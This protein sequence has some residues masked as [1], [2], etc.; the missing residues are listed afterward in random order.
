MDNHDDLFGNEALLPAQF[1]A[2]RGERLN[3]PIKRLALAVLEDALRLYQRGEPKRG[4]QARSAYVE[5]VAWLFYP[6]EGPFCFDSVCEILG[7]EAEYLRA[8]LQRWDREE[9]IAKR[10][11]VNG[12]GGARP[13][14]TR[15]RGHRERG[16]V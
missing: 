9:R 7:I 5:A 8:G 3:E 10:S 2:N 6:M 15:Y 16:R 11:A 12:N 14:L 1:Y 13:T 4:T